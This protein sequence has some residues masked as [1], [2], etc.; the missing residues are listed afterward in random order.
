MLVAFLLGESQ[1]KNTAISTYISISVMEIGL[2][3][4]HFKMLKRE[5]IAFTICQNVP[6]PGPLSVIQSC[7]NDCHH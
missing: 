4:H 2:T 1:E 5:K 7:L 6:E 3:M